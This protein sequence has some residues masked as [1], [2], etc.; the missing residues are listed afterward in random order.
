MSP[1]AAGPRFS[2]GTWCG[3]VVVFGLAVTPIVGWLVPMGFATVLGFLGLLALPAIRVRDEQRPTA[4]FLLLLLIW[5]AMSTAWSPYHPS[6]PGNNTALKLAAQLPLYWAVICAGWRAAPRLKTL[7]LKVL[8]WGAALFGVLLFIEF[9]TDV[10][11]YDYLHI[12]YLGP[13]RHDISQAHIAHS[14]FVLAVIWPLALAAAVKTRITP[15]VAVPAVAG[16]LAAAVRFGA[17]AP[18]LAVLLALMVGF[19]A[20]CW[21]RATPRA[22]AGLGVVYLL[23]APAVVWAVRASGR[24]GA[25]Q[26]AIPLSWSER[27][28]FWS[29]TVDWIRNHPLRG[30]GLDASR[31]FGPGIVLHPHD[32]ALQLW[33]ELGLVGV[34]LAAGV[35]WTT[36]SRLARPER[37]I[38][39]VA[40]TASASVYLLFGALNFG[41]WQEWWLALAALIAVVAA[42][43]GPEPEPSRAST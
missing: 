34:L 39:A 19:A 8:A 17:D 22:L 10:Q 1:A 36:V 37:D 26:D 2:L 7:G 15:W 27:M 35:W 23:A 14:S 6:K 42:L 18:V 5:A 20:W 11:V 9:A 41:V 3:W 12:H 33:L 21:P 28:G 32:D 25:I 43:M 30:W 4:V 29:H 38:G 16:L 31:M 13:I 40:V 24:Y